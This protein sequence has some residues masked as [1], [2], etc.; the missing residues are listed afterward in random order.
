MP[1]QRN[2]PVRMDPRAICRDLLHRIATL[3]SFA[4]WSAA[5][6]LP[7]FTAYGA[8]NARRPNIIVILTDDLGY[9]DLSC[10]GG[11]KAATPHIDAL[12]ARGRISP[13]A[14]PHARRSRRDQGRERRASR[15]GAGTP[16]AA[17]P[18]PRMAATAARGRR[19]GRIR[20]NN[21][22][23]QLSATKQNRSPKQT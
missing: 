3:G 19:R 1:A 2:A 22:V 9:G 17:H 13:A 20:K 21:G 18:L 10:H 4:V 8:E 23:E 12:A 15:N 16:R 6:L 7:N 14:L 11:T 5:A